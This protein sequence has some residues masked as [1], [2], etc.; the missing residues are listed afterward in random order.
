M[1]KLVSHFS[2][3]TMLVP[4]IELESSGLVASSLTR[5]ALSLAQSQLLPHSTNANLH[6]VILCMNILTAHFISPALH[7]HAFQ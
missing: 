3:F 6:T 1:Y 7:E 2:P 4:G 5:V